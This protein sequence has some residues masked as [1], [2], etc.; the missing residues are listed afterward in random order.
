MKNT[1]YFLVTLTNTDLTGMGNLRE[2]STQ[3]QTVRLEGSH[4][5]RRWWWVGSREIVCEMS[6]L[7]WELAPFSPPSPG[8]NINFF[9]FL[10]QV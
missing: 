8:S 2:G 9:G 7:K 1:L 4:K 5:E 6:V 10:F 3:G